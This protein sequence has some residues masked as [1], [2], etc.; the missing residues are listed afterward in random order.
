MAAMP[1]NSVTL[2]EDLV[3]TA[4]NAGGPGLESLLAN[5]G[6][7]RTIPVANLP[8]ALYSLSIRSGQPPFLPYFLY[9]FPLSPSTLRKERAGMGNFYDIAGIPQLAGVQRVPDVYGYSPPMWTIAGTTGVKR[10]STD[11]NLFTGLQSAL[12]LQAVLEQYFSLL[13]AAQSNASP[14]SPMTLPRL[15]L[16]DYFASD[17]WQVVPLGPMAIIQSNAAPQLVNYQIRL[18]G[19][20]SLA[21]PLIS[22]IDSILGPLAQDIS[23]GISSLSSTIQGALG[24]YNPWSP[25]AST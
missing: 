14:G 19:I 2:G 13:A 11:R 17:F 5:T 1:F 6:P 10:H 4:A 24:Q 16:Y 23:S 12:I 20:E 3:S 25:A 15:E 7:F 22:G 8:P 18:V 21:Q 9:T